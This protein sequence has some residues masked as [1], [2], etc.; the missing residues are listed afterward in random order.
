MK[1]Y[2]RQ[3]LSLSQV[4]PS[5]LHLSTKSAFTDKMHDNVDH[6][7]KKNWQKYLFHY[8]QSNIDVILKSVKSL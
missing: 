8:K 5:V 6:A 1:K 4:H 2:L 7:G 3:I